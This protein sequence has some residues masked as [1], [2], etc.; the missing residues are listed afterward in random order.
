MRAVTM[1]VSQHK[2]DLCIVIGIQQ[3]VMEIEI[4][5]EKE[6]GELTGIETIKGVQF[7][8]FCLAI[9]VITALEFFSYQVD[10]FC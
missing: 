5:K 2:G 6:T 7:F 1:K 9:L 8:S 3:I 4:A 10:S